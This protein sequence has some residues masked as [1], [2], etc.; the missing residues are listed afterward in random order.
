MCCM[1][2]PSVVSVLKNSIKNAKI[3][4]VGGVFSARKW[5]NPT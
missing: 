1:V 4:K 2:L 5:M 3:L